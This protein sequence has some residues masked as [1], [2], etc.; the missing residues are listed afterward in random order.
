MT[1]DRSCGIFTVGHGNRS[2]A[3]FQSLLTDAAI[4][5]VVDVRRYPASKR[6]P[7]FNEKVLRNSLS[8][9][10]IEYI[11]K[12]DALGGH[13]TESSDNTQ[14][15]LDSASLRAY[16]EHTASPEFR[17]TIDWLTDTAVTKRVAVMCAEHKPAHCHRTVVSDFLC[18][19]GFN[20]V[21]LV[22]PTFNF[23]HA[24]HANA[25]FEGG[26]LRY[27]LAQLDLF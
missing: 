26:T 14:T 3:V 5:V 20:V 10:T 19:Q 15:A 13:R 12:G 2:L 4:E 27:P 25:R 18:C 23:P 24:R 17:Q 8:A 1:P 16:A 6:N 21:H 11:F 22:E 9:Q 7:Q